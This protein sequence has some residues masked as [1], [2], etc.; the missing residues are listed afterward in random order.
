MS[1]FQ[2]SNDSAEKN[3][4]NDEI[5][6]RNTSRERLLNEHKIVTGVIKD[7][8][9]SVS[10]A[11]KLTPKLHKTSGM[12]NR[13]SNC[14]RNNHALQELFRFRYHYKSQQNIRMKMIKQLPAASTAGIL[15]QKPA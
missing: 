7:C 8:V 11:Y 15:A 14:S 6:I 12:R 10:Q 13:T 2:N 9:V 5:L 1:S 4:N 3:A